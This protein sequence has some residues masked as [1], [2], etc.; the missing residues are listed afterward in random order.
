MTTVRQFF[1][2][3]FMVGIVQGGSQALSRSLFAS[4]DPEAQ[5]VGVLRL[6]RRLR[7][8]RRHHRAARCSRP[9]V[10]LTG[11]SRNAILSVIAFF[12]VGA[13]LLWMVDVK[14]G[15]RAARA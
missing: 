8:V 12:V 6:L 15:Q 9:T 13:V 14:E 3:A 11:S 2:L 1:L 10:A 4:D 5:V 7:E